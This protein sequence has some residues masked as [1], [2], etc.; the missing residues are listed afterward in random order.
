MFRFIIEAVLILQKKF[1]SSI[2]V[3][4]KIE[5]EALHM[6]D[7]ITNAIVKQFHRK[8]KYK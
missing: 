2:A 1:Q 7:I 8:L 6:A 3:F 4:D 5:A